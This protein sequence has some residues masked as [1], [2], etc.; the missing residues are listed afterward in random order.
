V[1]GSP[2]ASLLAERVALK[3]N[4]QSSP[5]V[6]STTRGRTNPALRT[7]EARP[8]RLFRADVHPGRPAT[9]KPKSSLLYHCDPLFLLDV[10]A[11]CRARLLLITKT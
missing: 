2:A 11:V 7:V 10:R 1:F 9:S 3:K 6:A 5:T 4:R 8:T